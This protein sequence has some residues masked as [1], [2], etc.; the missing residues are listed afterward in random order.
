MTLLMKK[1]TGVLERARR[2]EASI[3]ST[4]E[5]AAAR[6][7]AAA[8]R[9]PI[10]VV[11]AVVDAVAEDIQP[12]GRG[13]S[14]FPFNVVRVTLLAPSPRAK[15]R[16]AAVVEGT[17]PLRERILARLHAAGCRDAAPAVTVSYTTRA[18]ADWVQTDFDV[19]CLRAD[20]A[21]GSDLPPRLELEVAGGTAGRKRHAF[22]GGPVAIGRGVDVTDRH[23]RLLRVNQVAFDESADEASRTVS[24]L[25]AH[26]EYGARARQYRLF[27]DGSAQ[28]TSVIRNSRGHAVSRGGPGLVLRSGDE[29]VIGRAR[30]RVTLVP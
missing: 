30:L 21:A 27:D 19:Q 8:D 22:G 12:A 13:R 24:R 16:L 1:F 3:A 29:I 14:A 7:A 6:M 17:A 10:E 23:G 28:G 9:Q 11:L 15:A 26:I 18:R 2:I 5:G 20:Q 4:V 25:H